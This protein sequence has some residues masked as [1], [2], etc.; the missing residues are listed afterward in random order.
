[1]KTKLRKLRRNKTFYLYQPISTSIF[2]KKFLT[3]QCG[4]PSLWL[5]Y[6]K[7]C[8]PTEVK[9]F[10]EAPFVNPQH[11]YCNDC[12]QLQRAN[13]I[14]CHQTIPK[15][16]FNIP[17]SWQIGYFYAQ[18]YYACQCNEHTKYLIFCKEISNTKE[19]F[20]NLNIANYDFLQLEL[21]QDDYHLP[22]LLFPLCSSCIDDLI[23]T[24]KNKV[25]VIR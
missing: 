20:Q 22:S 6:E 3:C 12:F 15:D 10:T 14:K 4:Q 13:K 7:K 16:H 2:S 24:T 1:M 5:F 19:Y 11:F 21:K 9:K 17:K 18:K 23:K 25:M 8:Q